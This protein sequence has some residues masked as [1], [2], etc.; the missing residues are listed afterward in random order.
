M[1][2]NL[3][4]EHDE[5]C[6]LIIWKWLNI[7][8]YPELVNL[9]A[10]PNGGARDVRTGAKLKA[11]G[12]LAGVPDLF[13]AAVRGKYHG[14][15]IEMKVKPNKPTVKQ[16]EVIQNLRKQGYAAYVCYGA[17]SAIELIGKY[18]REEL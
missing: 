8:K 10:I 3:L 17:D 16:T 15:F 2:A 14:L 4:S 6:A 9:F 11:E 12:V 13:L 1:S 18:L 5:Q 7:S